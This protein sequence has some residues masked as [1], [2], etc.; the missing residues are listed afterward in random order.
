MSPC[1]RW[2]IEGLGGSVSCPRLSTWQ[3]AEPRFEPKQPAARFLCFSTRPQHPWSP[4][5]CKS[6]HLFRWCP[7][8]G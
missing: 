2:K 8:E 4:L 6:I 1:C 5:A 7:R 3:K